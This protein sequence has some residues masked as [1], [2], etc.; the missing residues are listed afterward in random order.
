M[1]KTVRS[2]G[3]G[4]A[5]R[6]LLLPSRAV[7]LLLC[8][9][10]LPAAQAQ[11][12][13]PN[14]T[15]PSSPPAPAVAPPPTPASGGTAAPQPAPLPEYP[16]P[17]LRVED[18]RLRRFDDALAAL[19]AQGKVAVIAE[20]A[21]YR[22]ALSDSALQSLSRAVSQD[23]GGVPLSKFAAEVGRAFDYDAVRVD[24]D[25][26]LF[27]KRY[28]EPNDL[29]VV[30]F[31]E[32]V[33]ALRGIVRATDRLNPRAP[34]LG[35]PGFP[36]LR[37]VNSLD[38]QQM[39]ALK[40]GLLVTQLRPDQREWLWQFA[41]QDYLQRTMD[42]V[43]RTARHLETTRSR[44]SV[45]RRMDLVG[46]GI[47]IFGYEGPFGLRGAVWQFALS[48][49][50][51]MQTGGVSLL[52]APDGSMMV[53]GLL[54]R[55]PPPE[56]VEFLRGKIGGHLPDPNAPTTEDYADIA[57]PAPTS[58]VG[59]TLRGVVERLN[60]AA[61]PKETTPSTTAA[62]V[63]GRQEAAAAAMFRGA[64]VDEAL[65]S[66]PVSVVGVEA[67][68]P[69]GSCKPLPTCTACTFSSR[70]TACGC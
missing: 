42:S 17:I 37:F 20:G 28:S 60:A 49:G 33:R 35:S 69:S 65:Q 23:S 51:R 5:A 3:R 64:A 46:L 7:V 26:F 10:C 53:F 58:A 70:R 47:P 63:S 36:L 56:R 4:R 1:R 21:P 67:I 16:D 62:A 41:R 8:L 22:P 6:G 29:P 43:E 31:E 52:T 34:Q 38:P 30:T 66:K 13:Q 55:K 14:G 12:P 61:L 54:T 57:R 25:L 40:D 27:Y 2:T 15:V 32:A 18:A 44:K 11:K 45:F 9:A 48:H 19:A 68:A 50:F 39:H 59:A 24:R